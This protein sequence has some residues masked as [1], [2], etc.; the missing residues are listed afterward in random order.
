M[1]LRRP[2][3]LLET[4]GRARHDLPRQHL[5]TTVPDVRESL[6]HVATVLLPDVRQLP[7]CL[8]F[9]CG[10]RGKLPRLG[11]LGDHVFF[12]IDGQDQDVV[13]AG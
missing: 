7:S 5:R 12:A 4:I 10:N 6:R 9:V 2:S 1:R 8:P 13:C 3:R 11:V